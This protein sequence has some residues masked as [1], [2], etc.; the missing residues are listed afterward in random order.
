MESTFRSAA[1]AGRFDAIADD[2]HLLRQI[3]RTH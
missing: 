2:S 1:S 3:L